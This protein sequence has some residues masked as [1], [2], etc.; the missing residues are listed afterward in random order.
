MQYPNDM[1]REMIPICDAINEL[2]GT[3]TLFCCSGH[4]VVDQFY[5]LLGTSSLK[6]LKRLCKAFGDIDFDDKTDINAGFRF[7]FDYDF[8]KLDGDEIGVRISNKLVGKIKPGE[9]RKAFNKVIR[10]LKEGSKHAA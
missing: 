1:D 6:S 8:W 10:R 2:P 9:R 5:I 4:G 3:R 7:E